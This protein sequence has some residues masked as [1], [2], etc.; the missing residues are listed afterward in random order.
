MVRITLWSIFVTLVTGCSSTKYTF[1]YANCGSESWQ[2]LGHKTA[3]SGE[4]VRLFDAVKKT[5]GDTLPP[6]AQNQFVS[7]YSAGLIEYCTY[8]TGYQ[9]ATEGSTQTD[10]CPFD[11]QQAYRKGFALGQRKRTEIDEYMAR[12][13]REVYRHKQNQISKEKPRLEIR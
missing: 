7:G 1:D 6:N 12:Q 2:A 3:L 11:L 10:I 9:H 5:C 8:E 13:K 4:N